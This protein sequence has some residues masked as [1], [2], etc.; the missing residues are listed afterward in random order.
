MSDV[1]QPV[2]PGHPNRKVGARLHKSDCPWCQQ[3][4][5]LFDTPESSSLYHHR[6]TGR[7]FV[8]R[9][10]E[11]RPEGLRYHGVLWGQ[12]EAI[13]APSSAFQKVRVFVK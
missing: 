10:T 9:R 11:Q 3:L 7:F 13:Y 12:T 1:R 6:E 2:C 5:I 4:D 8:L